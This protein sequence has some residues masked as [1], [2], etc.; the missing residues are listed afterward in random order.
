MRLDSVL[1]M[2]AAQSAGDDERPERARSKY[3][4]ALVMVG[5][6]TGRK[7]TQLLRSH[8]ENQLLPWFMVDPHG[9]SLSLA[10]SRDRSVLICGGRMW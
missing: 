6:D 10:S 8:A 9:A 5:N 7:M 2:R 3:G 4:D 1:Q